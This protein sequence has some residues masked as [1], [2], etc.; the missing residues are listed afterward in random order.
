LGRHDELTYH[1]TE[2]DKMLTSEV[3]AVSCNH[4]HYS[5]TL[6]KLP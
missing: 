4:T 3:L 6:Q 1:A 5:V 2:V